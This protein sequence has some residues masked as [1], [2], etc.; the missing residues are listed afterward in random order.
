MSPHRRRTPL[1]E[2]AQLGDVLQIYPGEI[3]EGGVL[4]MKRYAKPTSPL[5]WLIVVSHQN[6]PNQVKIGITER[7]VT[8]M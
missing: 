1:V 7:P 8:R 4:W 6:A 3:P 5:E 2:I